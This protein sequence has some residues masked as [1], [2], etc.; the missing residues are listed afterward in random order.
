MGGTP[1]GKA[2][3]LR[4]DLNQGTFAMYSGIV[5]S[6]NSV[7]FDYFISFIL[8]FTFLSKHINPINLFWKRNPSQNNIKLILLFCHLPFTNTTQI[9]FSTCKNLVLLP[10]VWKCLEDY[11]A[12]KKV[13]WVNSSLGTE[14]LCSAFIC[15]FSQRF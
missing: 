4:Q 7:M 15:V 11:D 2:S 3:R 10:T 8:F 5:L 9:F 1:K 6:E 12:K 14:L 13:A